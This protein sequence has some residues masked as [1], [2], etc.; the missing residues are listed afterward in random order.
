MEKGK[1]EAKGETQRCVLKDLIHL[2]KRETSGYGHTT[3]LAILPLYA[4]CVFPP[5]FTMYG[6]R[7][8]FSREHFRF[9]SCRKYL[10]S[11]AI[12]LERFS[13]TGTT[14]DGAYARVR[15]P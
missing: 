9:R 3:I 5:T 6:S 8:L 10:G 15:S 12:L 14:P 2:G 11:K 1:A 7:L 4:V 13:C